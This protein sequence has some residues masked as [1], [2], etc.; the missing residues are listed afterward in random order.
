MN[1][2]GLILLGFVLGILATLL[3][4]GYAGW[5]ARRKEERDNGP[6]P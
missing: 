6:R 5:V 1:T 4:D 3:L 2:F